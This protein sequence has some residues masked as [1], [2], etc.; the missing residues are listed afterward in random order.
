[1]RRVAIVGSICLALLA[2][3]WGLWE[4]SRA[5]T[6]QLFGEV[7]TRVE[8]DRPVVALTFD[9]GPTELGVDAV[10]PVLRD[11]GVKATFF[12]TGAEMTAHPELGRRI[13]EAGHEIGNHSFTHQRMVFMSPSTVASEIE[14]TD[15]LIRETGYAG[16]IYFRAPYCKKLVVLPWYLSR[17]DRT[18]IM[19]DLEPET[20]PE[21]TANKERLTDYVVQNVRPGSIVLLHAMYDSRDT[22]REALPAI[23]DGLRARGFEF[24][25]VEQLLEIRDK[26]N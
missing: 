10:L 22:T 26:K 24:V 12:L 19:W 9:D 3:L 16:P 23:V 5:R 25:T 18:S 17:H 6:F 8:T 7:V 2:V 21:I 1:M 14:R 11:R 13:A 15:A 20:Y 4:L